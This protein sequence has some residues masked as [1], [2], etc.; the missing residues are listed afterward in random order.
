ML[1]RAK[2]HKPKI[3]PTRSSKVRPVLQ[4]YSA[5]RRYYHQPGDEMYNPYS[6]LATSHSCYQPG[7]Q[8]DSFTIIREQCC[9][10]SNRLAAS[11]TLNTS[12]MY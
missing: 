12:L 9:Q 3:A 2:A 4:N 10:L 5:T 6:N 1:W 7:D 11:I 8:K